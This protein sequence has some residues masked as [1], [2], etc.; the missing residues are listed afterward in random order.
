METPKIPRAL[1]DRGRRRHGTLPPVLPTMGA[2]LKTAAD[3][4]RE[5]SEVYSEYRTFL[6][7]I[8]REK[9]EKLKRVTTQLKLPAAVILTE[10]VQIDHFSS[11]GKPV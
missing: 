1:W 4:P 9:T 2:R 7:P 6:A 5:L 11:P 8:S 10:K 3:G